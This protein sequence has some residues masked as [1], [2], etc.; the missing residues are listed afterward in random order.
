M[1]VACSIFIVT[2]LYWKFA[3]EFAMVNKDNKALL[4]FT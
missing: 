4:K 3:P 2:R 1:H